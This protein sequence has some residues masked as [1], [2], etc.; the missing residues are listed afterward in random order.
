MKKTYKNPLFTVV[1]IQ[2]EE[3]IALSTLG[4]TD[5]TEGNLGREFE[6]SEWEEDQV[7]E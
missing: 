4:E 5:L 1:E 7:I 2:P 3:F 6:F